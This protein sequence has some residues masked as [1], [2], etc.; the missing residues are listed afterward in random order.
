MNVNGK[1]LASS[2]ALSAV[3]A[4]VQPLRDIEAASGLS[5][6][7]GGNNSVPELSAR[8]EGGRWIPSLPQELNQGVRIICLASRAAPSWH[9]FQKSGIINQLPDDPHR[10]QRGPDVK[11]ARPPLVPPP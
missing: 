10:A 9:I 2:P 4:R 8:P 3:G 7:S 1:S 5:D 11:G 6:L